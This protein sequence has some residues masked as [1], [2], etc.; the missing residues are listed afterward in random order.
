MQTTIVPRTTAWRQGK[1]TSAVATPQT[2][3]RRK[4][5][6]VYTHVQ[7]VG[8]N[9]INRAYVLWQAIL[10]KCSRKEEWLIQRRAEKS[11]R[12]NSVILVLEPK[13]LSLHVPLFPPKFAL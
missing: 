2:Q 1:G 6:H 12:S 9:G 7:F 13:F 3:T 8:S 5:V 10:S 11:G 4:E